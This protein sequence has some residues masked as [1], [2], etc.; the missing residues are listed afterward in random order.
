MVAVLYSPEFGA[1]WSTWAGEKMRETALFHPDIVAWV[2]T[3]KKGNIN[4]LIRSIFGED[5]FYT[6][7]AIDLKIM[8]LAVGTPFRVMECDGYESIEIAEDINWTIA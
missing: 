8:W 6:G 4:E 7:G 1:G 2:E 5:Y 3:G